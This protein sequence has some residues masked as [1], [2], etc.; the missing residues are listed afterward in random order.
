MLLFITCAD[1]AKQM[2][3]WLLRHAPLCAARAWDTFSTPAHAVERIRLEKACRLI[4][5]HR[6]SNKAVAVQCGFN[7]EEVMRRAFMRHLNV[8]PKG[9]RERFA[10]ADA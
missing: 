3:V 5:A 9:Y 6:H 2:D 4:E 10:A 1:S 7:S 8:S